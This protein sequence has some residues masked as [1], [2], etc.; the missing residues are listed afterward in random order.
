MAEGGLDERQSNGSINRALKRYGSTSNHVMRSPENMNTIQHEIEEGD[1]LQGLALKYGTTME[2]IRRANRL[3]TGDSLF[4]RETLLIPVP[5]EEAAKGSTPGSTGAFSSADSGNSSDSSSP[6]E[7]SSAILRE[8]RPHTTSVPTPC[9][10]SETSP[11]EFLCKID[12]AIAHTKHQV[13]KFQSKSQFSF[14]E[15]DSQPR[16]RACVSR[17]RLQPTAEATD[18]R[19]KQKLEQSQDAIF[20]L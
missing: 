19:L 16:R 12:T 2:Q 15:E 13:N 6:E 4:V 9:D 5:C 3:W 8:S 10:R 11:S 7:N 14:E 1:T 18:S 17:L 20:E